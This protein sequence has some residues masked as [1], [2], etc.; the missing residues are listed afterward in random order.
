M[1]EKTLNIFGNVNAASATNFKVGTWLVLFAQVINKHLQVN[2]SIRLE[3]R[4]A[5]T[6]RASKM[7]THKK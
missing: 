3:T 4:D 7:P 1:S 6:L 5:S 2:A